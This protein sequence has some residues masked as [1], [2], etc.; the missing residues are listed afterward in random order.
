[1]TLTAS[2]RRCEGRWKNDSGQGSR[3]G[4]MRAERAAEG[5][6]GLAQEA[7]ERLARVL[8]REFSKRVR[9]LTLL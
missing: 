5:G 1:M 3:R 8:A 4:R 2:C 7:R 9:T 6:G